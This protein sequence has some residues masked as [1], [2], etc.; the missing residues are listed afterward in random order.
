MNIKQLILAMTI[1]L[2]LILATLAR[3][4]V[5][6]DWG[7]V[8]TP[9]T[10]EATFSFEQYDITKNF[11]HQYGFSLEG[12]AGA[13]YQV[14]F[15]FDACKKGCGNPDLSYGIY[16]AN[17]GLIA[18]ASGTVTLSAGNYVFQVKGTGMGSGNSLDYMGSVTFSATA[19]VSPVPEPSTLLLTLPGL[20][21]VHVMIRRRR[22]QAQ[23]EDTL[24][25]RS[26]PLGQGA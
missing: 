26:I 22:R 7:T 24:D 1:G 3:A 4:E 16:N 9:L 10:T 6:A 21:L 5:V 23:A 19:M 14:T 18:D 17:G 20:A 25:P 12:E 8:V 2:G 13:T 15:T 11:T